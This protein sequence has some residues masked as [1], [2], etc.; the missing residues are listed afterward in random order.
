MIHFMAAGPIVDFFLVSSFVI[1][2]QAFRKYLRRGGLPYP[3]GPRALPVIGN[4]LDIPMESSWLT[5][6]QLAKKY[7]MSYVLFTCPLFSEFAGDVMSFHVLGRVVVILGS[8]KATKDL[9]GKRGNVYSDR[10]VIPFFEMYAHKFGS[11]CL[12]DIVAGW[13]YSGACCWRDMARTGVFDARSSNGA[14]GLGPWKCIVTSKK[15]KPVFSLLACCKHR[16]SG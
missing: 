9:L 1:V 3:P 16:R 8:T 14:S 12:V 5:Y 2:L 4:L 10:P 13:M 7:G 6:S 11:F 15:R